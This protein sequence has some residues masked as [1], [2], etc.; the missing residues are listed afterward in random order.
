V[1]GKLGM[2]SGQAVFNIINYA[3]NYRHF[4]WAH[5][6]FLTLQT[7]GDVIKEAQINSKNVKKELMVCT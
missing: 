3:V 4:R 5:G 6:S 2:P 1:G 7:G